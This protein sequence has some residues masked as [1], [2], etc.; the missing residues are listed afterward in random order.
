MHSLILPD[1]PRVYLTDGGLE[2]TLIFDQGIDLP[3]FAAF[4]LLR[5]QQGIA[6]LKAYYERYIAIASRAGT[7]FVLESPTWRANPD[8]GDRT[9][10]SKAALADANFA[11]IN[12]LQQLRAQYETRQ[13]PML[14][15]GCVG[16]RGDGY[17]PGALMKPEVAEAYHNEQ[18][19]VFAR[20]GVD[21]INA[22]TLSNAAEAIGIVRAAARNAIPCVISFTLETD[23]RLPTGQ[24]LADAIAEVDAESELRPA[25]Y[26]INCAH[27]THF[28]SVLDNEASWISRIGGLRANASCRSHAEL[29]AASELD[30]GDPVQLASAHAELHER[31][32]ALRVFGGCCGTDQEHIAAIC[33][34][35]TNPQISKQSLN[36]VGE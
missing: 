16:P 2:T 7:G 29:D 15:S 32:P 24:S 18:I 27:P 31:L 23:G 9:G 28:I 21:L 26:M 30:R 17:I 12:M 35:V 22:M 3:H 11:G 1:T 34:A 25:Y 19:S 20:A 8:W 33:D 10:Y 5:D 6:T 13:M 36:A 4:T 14:I